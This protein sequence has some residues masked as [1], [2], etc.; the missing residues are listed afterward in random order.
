MNKECSPNTVVTRRGVIR[1]TLRRAYRAW[2]SGGN[3]ELMKGVGPLHQV[4]TGP[5][6]AA[7]S[8]AK[9]FRQCI[10]WQESFRRRKNRR[11]TDYPTTTPLKYRNKLR[12]G[13]L[14]VQGLS[15]RTAYS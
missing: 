11:P 2:R 13:S 12:I 8:R 7:Q 5:K 9:W 4:T 6:K 14:N 1:R 3:K 10:H 15:S